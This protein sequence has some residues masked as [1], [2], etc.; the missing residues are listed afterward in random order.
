MIPT[1]TT[2]DH[3]QDQTDQINQTDKS[4]VEFVKKLIQIGDIV[5]A[6]RKF[7]QFL[8]VE[9]D[10]D[11]ENVKFLKLKEFVCSKEQDRM[12]FMGK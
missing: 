10:V 9:E 5:E 1:I 11:M 7:L 4:V 3:L 12:Q 2:Q 6:K 8:F